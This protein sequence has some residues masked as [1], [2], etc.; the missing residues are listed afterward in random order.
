[1]QK[2]GLIRQGVSSWHNI[3]ESEAPSFFDSAPKSADRTT[4]DP[5]A[6][7]YA[8]VPVAPRTLNDHIL[9]RS[10]EGTLSIDGSDTK[11]IFAPYSDEMRTGSTHAKNDRHLTRHF[12]PLAQTLEQIDLSGMNILEVGFGTGYVSHLVLKQDIKSLRAYDIQ[13]PEDT[14]IMRGVMNDPRANLILHDYKL[15]DF[16]FMAE[17]DWAVISNPPYQVITDMQ[18]RLIEPYNPKGVVLINSQWRT[19]NFPGYTVEQVQT[20]A[21]FTPSAIGLHFVIANGFEG[22]WNRPPE[23]DEKPRLKIL[24]KEHFP[25]C[26]SDEAGFDPYVLKEMYC[27]DW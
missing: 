10:F 22:R 11:V 6:Y 27:F 24:G 5:S 12:N 18:Q 16:S 1:M 4:L 15:D 21:D 25:N 26:P 13:A 9:R 19:R 20:G 23:H 2:Y 8:L 3:G 7:R 14:E 17:G